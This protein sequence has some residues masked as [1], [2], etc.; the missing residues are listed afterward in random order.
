MNYPLPEIEL[1]KQYQWFQPKRATS[2]G[3]IQ[4]VKVWLSED[5]QQITH[6]IDK[7]V[8]QAIVVNPDD[9]GSDDSV[10]NASKPKSSHKLQSSSSLASS[11]L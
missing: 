4:D 11:T 7:S 8:T 10:S 6:P 9:I 5:G 3:F 1:E 2:D